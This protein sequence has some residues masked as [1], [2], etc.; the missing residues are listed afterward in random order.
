MPCTIESWIF[1]QFLISVLCSLGW[2]YKPLFL[3]LQRCYIARCLGPG[4][5]DD[6][7]DGR[8]CRLFFIGDLYMP[9]PFPFSRYQSFRIGDISA[10]E[11][12]QVYPS[13]LWGNVHDPVR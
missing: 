9:H 2:R 6:F 10:E 4:L 11:E 7:F 12:A 13:V 8:G 1:K 3:R 5:L